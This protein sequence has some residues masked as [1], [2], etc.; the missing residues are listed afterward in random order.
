MSLRNEVFQ[1]IPFDASFDV[2]TPLIAVVGDAEDEEDHRLQEKFFSRFRLFYRLLGLVV[3]FFGNFST[4]G[5]HFLVVTIWGEDAVIKTKTGII[6]VLILFCSFFYSAA[7][8][9]A[10]LG[11]LRNL[12]AITYSAIGGRSKELLEEMV[13]HME[14]GFVVGTMV[15]LSIVWPMAAVRWG[16]RAQTMPMYSLTTLLVV[17]FF[18]R[19]IM[20]MYCATKIKPSLSRRSAAEQNTV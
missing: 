3:G 7:I 14:Y 2:N 10:I 18:W 13:L 12:V 6:F 20:V 15:G 19:K 11:F 5:G 17:A 8:V 16:T 9:F 4:L 1:T